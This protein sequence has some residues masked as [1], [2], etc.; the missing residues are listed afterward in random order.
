MN[1]LLFEVRAGNVNV[2][3]KFAQ[4]QI[5]ISQLRADMVTKRQFQDLEERV[6]K[7]ETTAPV[8]NNNTAEF[9]ALRTQLHRLCILY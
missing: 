1:Q 4:V 9:K 5:Q 3:E 6:L 2:N 7:L 8:G